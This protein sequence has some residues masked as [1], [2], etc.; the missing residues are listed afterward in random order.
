MFLGQKIGCVPIIHIA[1]CGTFIY[2]FTLNVAY[3]HKT[4]TYP[5]SVSL[6][7]CY[8]SGNLA[9]LNY[10]ALADYS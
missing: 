8:Q 5:C 1:Y 3:I 2:G 7:M 6:T 10:P 4:N 9:R